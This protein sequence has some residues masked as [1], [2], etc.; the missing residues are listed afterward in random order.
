MF[1]FIFLLYEA[2]LTWNERAKVLNGYLIIGIAAALVLSIFL[3]K[4]QIKKE[5]RNRAFEEK[6]KASKSEKKKQRFE[7]KELQ[8]SNKEAYNKLQFQWRKKILGLKEQDDFFEIQDQK[9]SKLTGLFIENE[10]IATLSVLP[11]KTSGLEIQNFTVSEK[12]RGLGYASVLLKK[13]IHQAKKEDKR[14]LVLYTPEKLNTAITVYKKF[15]FKEITMGKQEKSE[16]P[17]HIKMKL[18]L[19]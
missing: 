18:D 6:R 16:T 1:A 3:I 9:N 13:V 8:K 10:L 19:V 14:Y 12:Y 17:C 15:D 7:I 2:G 4:S 5:K 11:H